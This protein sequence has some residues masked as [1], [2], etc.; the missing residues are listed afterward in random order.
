MAD[1]K[2]IIERVYQDFNPD[3]IS[4]VPDILEKYQG[5]EAELLLKLS[6]KYDVR[7]EN[8]ISI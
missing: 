6:Q 3:K 2:K 7:L 1:I 4:N 8:Y 5:N